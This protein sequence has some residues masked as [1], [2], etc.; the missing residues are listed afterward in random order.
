MNP[1]SVT[2]T[3]LYGN[4]ALLIRSESGEEAVKAAISSADCPKSFIGVS[5]CLILNTFTSEKVLVD[6]L[7]GFAKLTDDE[8]IYSGTACRNLSQR[9][10]DQ[11]FSI[12]AQIPT[13]AHK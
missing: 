5:A 3:T 12:S 1:Y 4:V 8:V 6:T 13:S 9:A 2:F 11:Y 10:L 7:N